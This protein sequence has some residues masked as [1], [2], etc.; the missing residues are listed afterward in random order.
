MEERVVLN[1]RRAEEAESLAPGSLQVLIL[2]PYPPPLGGVSSHIRRLLPLLTDAGVHVR[3][4]NHFGGGSD[5]RFVIGSLRRDPA[6]Y[7][8]LPRRFRPSIVHYHHSRLSSLVA[9]ALGR[10]RG[11]RARYLITVHSPNVAAML[12]SRVAPLRALTRWAL[13]R[14]DEAIA[15]ND[16]IAG[17]LREAVP[18][19]EVA[20]I[21]AFLPAREAAAGELP[22]EV[23]L[24]LASSGRAVVVSA[25][26]ISFLRDGAD[27]YGLDTTIDAF[28]DLARG[29]EALRLAIFIGQRPRTRRGRAYLES[30]QARVRAAGLA[31]RVSLVTAVPLTPAFRHDVVFVRPTR[32]DGDALSI[33]EALLCGVPVIA[34]DIVARPPDVRLFPAGDARALRNAV[35]DALAAMPATDP[36][37]PGSDIHYFDELLRI[38]RRHLLLAGGA[39]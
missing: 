10:R 4:L 21:P 11:G 3:V 30:L 35:A 8:L 14:F 23:E 6:R 27:L 18:G 29:D 31:D 37:D 9:V 17:D 28:A 26:R 15:V 34:S 33:R 36:R 12:R 5:D 39:S 20:V 32:S 13:G 25:Y 24:F 7:F 38:Y 22:R 1:R 16:R 19:L 2:G